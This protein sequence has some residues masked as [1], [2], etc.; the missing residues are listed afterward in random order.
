MGGAGL[1]KVLERCDR[2][3]RRWMPPPNWSRRDWAQEARAC[4]ALAAWRAESA[5][6]PERGVP[7][8]R[9]VY[10]QAMSAALTRYRQEW[11]FARHCPVRAGGEIGV[12][13][14]RSAPPLDGVMLD[15]LLSQFTPM[16]RWLIRQMFVAQRTELDLARQLGVS[17]QAVSRRKAALRLRLRVLMRE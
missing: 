7:L 9:Y 4:A 14:R 2:R 12:A 1:E 10:S 6:N 8:E 5:F 13:R 11:S 3:I 16:D 17:Q 15:E